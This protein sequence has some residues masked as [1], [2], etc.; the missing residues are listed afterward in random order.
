MR[1]ALPVRMLRLA[2][3]LVLLGLVSSGCRPTAGGSGDAGGDGGGTHPAQRC[4]DRGLCTVPTSVPAGVSMD[5]C[6]DGCNWCTCNSA[7]ALESCTARACG[8]AGP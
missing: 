2:G 6:Y 1:R 3:A 7:G 5:S 8:D 4:I